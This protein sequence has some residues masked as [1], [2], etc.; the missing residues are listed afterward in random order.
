MTYSY[1]E[2]QANEDG[3]SILTEEELQSEPTEEV[4]AQDEQH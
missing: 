2:E 3:L 4:E 1:T